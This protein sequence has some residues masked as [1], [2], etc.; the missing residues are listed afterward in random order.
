M[1][2]QDSKQGGQ[3]QAGKLATE[4]SGRASKQCKKKGRHRNASPPP[5]ALPHKPN[6]APRVLLV[7]QNSQLL[8]STGQ[9]TGTGTN[10]GGAPGGR[11]VL[12]QEQALAAQPKKK[13]MTNLDVYLTSHRRPLQAVFLPASPAQSLYSLWKVSEELLALPTQP[14]QPR[15]VTWGGSTRPWEIPAPNRLALQRE[16]NP[17]PPV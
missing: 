12:G 15:W 13:R 6:G 9:E 1:F 7:C 11:V 10:G 2:S 4:R 14:V 8:G 16:Q 3:T 17:H 5:S